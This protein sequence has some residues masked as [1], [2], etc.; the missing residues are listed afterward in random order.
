MVFVHFGT[1]DTNT[2]MTCSLQEE[3]TASF[4]DCKGVLAVVELGGTVAEVERFD[5]YHVLGVRLFCAPLTEQ[6]QNQIEAV[7]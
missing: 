3:S 2:R 7:T 1:M 4:W 5:A 6:N